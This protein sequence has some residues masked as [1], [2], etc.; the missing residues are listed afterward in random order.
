[1]TYEE[2]HSLYKTLIVD[3]AYRKLRNKYI[4]A[5]PL[6]EECLKEGRVSQATEVHHIRRIEG[7]GDA[8]AMKRRLMD[9][10]NLRSLCYDCHREAHR[11]GGGNNRGKKGTQ[12]KRDDAREFARRFYG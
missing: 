2:R 5:H 10:D 9:W 4:G 7:A 8:A 12:A 1:M 11:G 6:C 3:K